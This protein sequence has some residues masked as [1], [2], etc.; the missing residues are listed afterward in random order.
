MSLSIRQHWFIDAHGRRVLLRGVNLG[1]STKLPATPDGA[2]HLPTDFSDHRA[3]SF[4]GRP[5]PLA[6]A[7]EHYAR[8]R[9]WGFNSLRLLTTWE[10]VEHAGPGQHDEAYL[11]YLYRVAQ[12]AGEYGFYV[13]IDPHQDMW[14]RMSGGDGAPGWTLELAGFD[15]TKLDASEAAI[16][17]QQRGPAY[18]QMIWPTNGRRLASGT[19]FTLFFAGDRF[20]PD[21]TIEGES[22]QGFLQ[23]HFIASMTAIAERL[24]GF[25][26]VIGYDSLNEPSAGFI[27]VPS[28]HDPIR[29][30]N[31]GPLFSIFEGMSIAAGYP[32]DVPMMVEQ[33]DTTRVQAGSVT[34]NPEGVSA[35]ADPAADIWRQHGVWDVDSG[36]APVLL[37]EDYFAGVDFFQDCVIPFAYRYGEAIRA[38]DADAILFIEGEPGSPEPLVWD[39]DI[40]VV[41]ASHWYDVLMLHTKH[42]DPAVCL[43]WEGM[44][45]PVHG[46]EAVQQSF[47]NQIGA[48]VANS[49]RFLDN[50]PT[51]IGEFG[52][53][54]DLD[55]GQAYRDG[56]YTAHVQALDSYYNAMDAHLAHTA[57]W[58]YTADNNNQWGD[59]WNQ[60]DLSIFSRD[61]QDNPDDLDSG[62]R[63]V[64]GFCRPHVVACA[65]TPTA[66]SFDLEAGTF[67]LRFQAESGLAAPVGAPTT[68]YVPRIQYPDGFRVEVSA[69]ATSYDAAAQTLTW[70]VETAGPQTLTLS[71]R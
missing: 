58:N 10:A 34:L 18:T 69:G 14:S 20:A 16:T 56:D 35:W 63:A 62:G 45:K 5:F 33:A 31:E 7:D 51:L 15:V 65:G 2:T 48:H 50:A 6:E 47:I 12:K 27:G 53:A 28:L 22:A 9:H 4:V 24:A 38:V 30:I 23:R 19:M 41:N 8:L 66:Q 43:A 67:T 37:R 11:D 59:K 44:R 25:D 36:G 1:G 13:F 57:Q 21:F 61:Q 68:V 39:S 42:Y 54:Y 64:R 52:L 32:R 26:H 60:E 46:A 71:R 49:R 17:H 40:P 70:T 55:G 29:V 3:L